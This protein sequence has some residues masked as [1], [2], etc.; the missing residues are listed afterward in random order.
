MD[1][2][3]SKT[4][5]KAKRTVNRAKKRLLK[6]NSKLLARDP[7]DSKYFL[8][9]VKGL[10]TNFCLTSILPLTCSNGT[11]AFSPKHKANCLGSVFVLVFILKTTYLRSLVILCWKMKHLRYRT[12]QNS[13]NTCVLCSWWPWLIKS[14]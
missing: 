13:H 14:S 12:N 4:T 8:S 10:G 9:T 6:E 2:R 5:Q 11:T 1:L 7:Y 3:P